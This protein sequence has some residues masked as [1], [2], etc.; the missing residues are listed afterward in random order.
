MVIDY[1]FIHIDT[2]IIS[3][4]DVYEIERQL[5]DIELIT[6]FGEYSRKVIHQLGKIVTVRKFKLFEGRY[7]PME[8]P[9]VREFVKTVQKH[10]RQYYVFVKK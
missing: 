10:D 7:Q 4:P 3:I 1:P 5:K 6:R 8:Y 9:E 2:V